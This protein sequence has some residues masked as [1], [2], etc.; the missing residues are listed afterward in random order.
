MAI[1]PVDKKND[2]FKVWQNY[3]QTKDNTLREKLILQYVPLVKYVAERIVIG[4]PNY[5]DCND[6][7][8]YG[9]LGLIESI[10]RFDPNRGVKFE[11]YAIARIRGAIFDG[12]NIMD[13]FPAS[14]RAKMRK[15]EKA[16][17]ILE[18]QL[19]RPASD[20]EIAIYLDMPLEKL[21]SL[22]AE[23][24]CLTLGSLD[25]V[26]NSGDKDAK[27][28]TLKDCIE[29]PNSS[30][31]SVELELEE[32]KKILG[33]AIDKLPPQEKILVSLYYYEGLTTKEISKVMEVS[34]SRISQLHSKAILRLRG[35]LSRMKQSLIN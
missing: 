19:S 18:Q 14:L 9:I 1:R 8:N 29:D 20:G 13:W 11:T 17:L 35:S 4:L 23:V 28:L 21:H 10:E 24:S 31:L 22:L 2:I 32:V 33:K 12:L 34:S 27:E 3:H 7:V 15:L 5:L 6:L 26:W 30:N 16:Y 25:E